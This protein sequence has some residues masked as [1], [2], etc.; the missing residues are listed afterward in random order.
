ME[1]DYDT[2]KS[3]YGLAIFT[4]AIPRISINQIIDVLSMLILNTSIIF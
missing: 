4:A 2:N 1:R 3:L